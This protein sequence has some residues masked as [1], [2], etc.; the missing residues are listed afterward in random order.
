MDKGLQEKLG[1][2]RCI[3]CKNIFRNVRTAFRR[4]RVIFEY[5]VPNERHFEMNGA[6]LCSCGG[7]LEAV[8]N[9]QKPD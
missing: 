3:R 2:Y 9:G 7:K 8:K 4:G 6:V 1:D 5:D